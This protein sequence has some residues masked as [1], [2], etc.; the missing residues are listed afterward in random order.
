MDVRLGQY[1]WGASSLGSIR[2]VDQT[3]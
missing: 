1:R 3:W 2:F